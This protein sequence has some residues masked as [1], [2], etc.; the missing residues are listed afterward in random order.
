MYDVKELATETDKR[1][2]IHEA[3]CAQRYEVIQ[4]RFDEGSKRMNKI[5]YLLYGVIVCVLFGPG[6]AAEFFKKLLSL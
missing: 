6:V 1:L 3:I 2:S 4:E 5:E